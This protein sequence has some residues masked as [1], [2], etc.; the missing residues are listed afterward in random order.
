MADRPIIFAAPMIRALLSGRKTQTRRVVRD[1]PDGR[2]F[3]DARHGGLDWVAPEGSPRLPIRLPYAPGD[4]LWVRETWLI[5]DYRY[6]RPIPKSRP[7]DLESDDVLYRATERDSEA[8]TE[9]IWRGAIHMPRWAS[10]LT[11]IVT[12]VRVQRLQEISAED[13]AAEGACE[14]AFAPPTDED[15]QEARALLRDLWNSLHG[16]DAWDKNP[17]VVA[18]SFDVHRG[19]IDQATGDE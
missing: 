1:G 14:L 15:T 18:L 17:W 13:V 12:D 11:L 10:R 5:N 8:Q 2:W 9:G 19:N 3:V 4:R 7:D 6:E 16:P